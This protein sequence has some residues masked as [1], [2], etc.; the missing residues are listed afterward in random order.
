MA[1][2]YMEVLVYIASMAGFER[3]YKESIG[4]RS[5]TDQNQLFCQ[6]VPHTNF[7]VG[8]LEEDEDKDEEEED[9]GNAIFYMLL[10]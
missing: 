7:V 10:L 2:S 3:S 9:E 6:R 4:L 1:S 5:Y 8:Q